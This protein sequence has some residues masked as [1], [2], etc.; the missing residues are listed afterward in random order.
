MDY[1]LFFEDFFG[2]RI[3]QSIFEKFEILLRFN[4]VD[5]ARVYIPYSQVTV[6]P[7]TNM[8]RVVIRRNGQ[9]LFSGPILS[10]IREWNENDLLTLEAAGDLYLLSTRLV[11]P[12]PSGPPY[13]AAAADVRIGPIET[14]LH[15][16]VYYHAGAGA[17][18][19]RR[20][21]GLTQAADEGR[22]QEV[23]ARGRFV[24]LLSLLQ[25]LANLGNLGIRMKDLK[26]EVFEP[27][28]LSSTVFFGPDFR[29]LLQFTHE[30]SVPNCN[31]M[32]VG[33]GGEGTSRV[34]FERENSRS[35]LRWGRIEN[36]LDRRDTSEISE[37]NNA[38]E[39][40]LNE[41]L[42]LEESLSIVAE[43]S[44]EEVSPGDLVSVSFDG[45]IYQIRVNE[46]QIEFD[47][48]KESVKLSSGTAATPRIYSR[49]R[50]I[51]ERVLKLEV[52]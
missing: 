13:S 17:K 34:V 37:L 35:I 39:V 31:Y 49:V 47:G 43:T 14:L 25:Q 20:I 9:I 48:L 3:G 50:L 32:F 38:A 4:E 18:S 46:L 16:Y 12:V 45:H 5:R 8:Y 27:R 30:V 11:V 52:E 41:Q 26:F 21:P 42:D 33:G 28:D 7:L 10:A 2:S 29:N 24:P 51:E 36:W 15:E 1:E 23:T 40:L 6:N 22:G 19:E 44:P